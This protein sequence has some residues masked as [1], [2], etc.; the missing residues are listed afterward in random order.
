MKQK[1]KERIL[2]RRTQTEK[3]IRDL[4]AEY[5]RQNQPIKIFCQARGLAQVAV[6]FLEEKIRD[7]PAQRRP[8]PWL[9]SPASPQDG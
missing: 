7:F 3:E 4:L 1:R 2:G 6:L 8:P 5:G 9:Y